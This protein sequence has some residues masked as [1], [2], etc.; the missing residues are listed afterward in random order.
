[1]TSYLINLNRDEERLSAQREQFGRLGISFERVH[2][3]ESA[4]YDKFRWWCAVLRPV[5]RGELGCAASH[6]E[7]YRR[8][9]ASQDACAAVFEDDV[10]LSDGIRDALGEAERF[11]TINREAVVL[12]GSH[13]RSKSGDIAVEVDARSKIVPIEWDNCS[14]GYVIGRDAA[15]KLLR[16]Q[17]PVR[18]PADWWRY[19]RKKGWIELFH[20]EPSVCA[21]QVERFKSNIE[22]RYVANQAGA[23]GRVWWRLRRIVGVSIDTLMDGRAGW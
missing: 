18:V 15:L 10:L 21:Q 14:E 5:V 22:E 4:E 6:L 8:L 11:C 1:M 12:L 20:S 9:L 7:C 23:L 17:S 2:A 16:G 13:W 19:F 3:S